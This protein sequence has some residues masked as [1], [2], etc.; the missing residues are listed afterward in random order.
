MLE[1]ITKGKEILKILIN[2]GFE[3]Y[4]VGEVV[5]N[6]IMKIPFNEVEITTSATPEAVKG[7]FEFTKNEVINEGSVNVVYYGYEFKIST[8]RIQDYKD[9]RTLA[10]VHYSKNLNDDL[11]SRDYTIDAIAMSHSEKVMDGFN[12]YED[13]RKKRIRLIGKPQIRFQEDPLRIL[14]GIRLVSELNFNLSNDTKKAMK[15]K[16]KGLKNISPEKISL[17]LARIFN[18][19][20]QKKAIKLLILLK[21]HKNIPLL[22][23]TFKRLDKKFYKFSYE[24]FLLAA[25]IINGN[26]LEGFLN[27]IDEKDLFFKAYQLATTNP[28]CNFSKLEM[29]NNKI[30]ICLFVNNVNRYLKKTKK[31]HKHINQKYNQLSIKDISDIAFGENDIKK[32]INNEDFDKISI[33]QDQVVYAI[34]EGNLVND[35]DEVKN[36]VIIKL[37]DMNI[38]VIGENKDFSYKSEEALNNI[39]SFKEED[40]IDELDIESGS[41]LNAKNEEEIASSLRKQGQVIK[42]YTEY[43]L[44]ILERRINEQDRII[45]EK[46]LQYA[47]LERE[48]RSRRIKEDIEA[49]VNKNLDLLKEL[50]YL[51]NPHKNK[52]ELGKQL[53]K[54]YLDYINGI[55][56]KY[57][58]NEVKNEE[59]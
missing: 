25:S 27:V 14:K 21:I 2:N 47:A 31:K 39:T 37:K 44:D 57:S 15:R 34:L 20:Y 3:A 4:F 13:I 53:Q 11:K 7:I 16:S 55:E 33:I 29:F 35:Y 36:F 19:P 42:D 12:G 50:N 58:I 32:L 38:F 45:R 54:V 41:L 59:N 30:E 5:R 10:K 48:S 8:F 6:N 24:E 52:L 56:D 9:K 26:V 22:T 18:L 23:K 1:Y 51:D 40:V 28:K 43:R 46:D 49:L 17:E